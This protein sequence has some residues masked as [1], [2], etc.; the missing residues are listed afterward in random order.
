VGARAPGSGGGCFYL[1]GPGSEVAGSG[2]TFVFGTRKRREFRFVRS[3][4][5]LLSCGIDLEQ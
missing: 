4:R 5:S 2:C 1:W 3:T